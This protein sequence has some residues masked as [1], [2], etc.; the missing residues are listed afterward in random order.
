[1]AGDAGLRL[2][3]DFSHLRSPYHR[4]GA[5]PVWSGPAP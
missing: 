1:M 3:R 5:A 4:G 2:E